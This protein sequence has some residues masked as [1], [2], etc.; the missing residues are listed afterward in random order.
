MQKAQ[1]LHIPVLSRVQFI[2]QYLFLDEAFHD[3]D[4]PTILPDQPVSD[5][6]ASSPQQGGL[7]G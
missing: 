4:Q 1:K 5:T 6:Q 3:I 7:F 2:K